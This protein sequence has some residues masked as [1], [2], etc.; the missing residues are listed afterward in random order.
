MELASKAE[1]WA[2]ESQPQPHQGECSRER[3]AEALASVHVREGPFIKELLVQ[4][5]T[6]HNW[7]VRV[8]NCT[9]ETRL[10]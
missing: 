3:A 8:E 2:S 10:T 4:D 9:F 1:M 6:L 7:T 5:K